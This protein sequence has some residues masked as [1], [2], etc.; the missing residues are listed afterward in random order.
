MRVE[1][2][3]MKKE[4][5]EEKEKKEDIY[6]LLIK[7]GLCLIGIAICIFALWVLWNLLLLYLKG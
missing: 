3:R 5:K 2:G 6:V 1:D 7:M 4:K